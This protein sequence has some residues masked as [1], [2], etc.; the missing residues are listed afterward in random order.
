[1]YKAFGL[2]T[3]IQK[4]RM[5]SVFL[6]ASFVL[7]IHAVLFS[8]VLI[9]EAVSYEGTAEEIFEAAVDDIRYAWPAGIIV[10]GLWFVIAFLF[11]Q[12]MIDFA[13][14][15]QGIERRQEPKVYNTLENL[16]ISRGISMPK[17]KIIESEGLNAF[18]SGI[19]QGNYSVAVTRGLVE[20]LSERELECVL[21]HELTHIRNRDTQM[22]VIAVIFAGIIAFIADI[23]FRRLDFPFGY[24]PQPA[25]SQGRTERR[26]DGR[27]AV[28]IILIAI[29]VI[30]ISWGVSVLIRFAISRSRE[31]LADAGAVE[32]T[33]EPDAMISALRRIE[34][35][36]AIPDMPSRMHAFFI[37]SPA[38]NPGSGWFAN[39]PS[40]D[41]RVAALVEFAGGADLADRPLATQ[42][43]GPWS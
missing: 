24:S 8:L 41:E 27:G 6:L 20:A 18:A 29:A 13:T 43:K 30:A 40:V 33:K 11:H 21:A 7:L 10:A 15:A 28:I 34:A 22:M 17:L 38:L 3:Y 35:R 2:Y 26:G 25:R 37:E 1:M 42:S 16:C 23:M 14:R 36:A 19:R 32:L 4:N 12:K 31:F 39:H 5:K 9:F